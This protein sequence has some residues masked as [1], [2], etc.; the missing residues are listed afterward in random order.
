MLLNL[1]KIRKNVGEWMMSNWDMWVGSHPEAEV[2]SVFLF[3]RWRINVWCGIGIR[4]GEHW[5][6]MIG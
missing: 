6:K 3:L 5:N 1:V 4:S 2:R